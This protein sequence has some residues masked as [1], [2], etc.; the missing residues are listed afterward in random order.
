MPLIHRQIFD[1]CGVISQYCVYRFRL[2]ANGFFDY[3]K[4]YQ[5]LFL[6]FQSLPFFPQLSQC[7]IS[8]VVYCT[9]A[10]SIQP[11][12]CFITIADEVI[13]QQNFPP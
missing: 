13:K 9:S 3:L 7:N 1:V 6:M 11:A 10:T 4:R 2:S 8:S 5:F 12:D